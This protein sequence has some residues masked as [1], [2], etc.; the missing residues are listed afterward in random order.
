MTSWDRLPAGPTL[1]P[2]SR[3]TTMTRFPLYCF[4]ALALLYLVAFWAI[5]TG[6]MEIGT[7]IRLCWRI[8]NEWLLVLG[9]TALLGIGVLLLFFLGPSKVAIAFWIGSY[10][11]IFGILM[12][13]LG[14]RLWRWDRHPVGQAPTLWHRARTA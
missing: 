6:A 2:N 4:T 8:D 14:L 3:D 10:A 9:G 5:L 11:V 1:L 7:A 13:A 12:V